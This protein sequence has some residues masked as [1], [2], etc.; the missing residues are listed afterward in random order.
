MLARNKMADVAAAPLRSHLPA[1]ADQSDPRGLLKFTT[2]IHVRY[3][4]LVPIEL[5]ISPFDMSFQIFNSGFQKI[6][7]TTPKLEICLNHTAYPWAHEAG[8]YIPKEDQMFV[9]SNRIH[10]ADGTQKIQISKISLRNDGTCLR[11]EI[12][13]DI[14]MANGGVNYKDGVLFCSQGT[15]DQPSSLIFMEKTTPYKC[16]VILDSFYGRQFN[17]INDVVVHGDGSIWFTDPIYG[18]E[19]NFRPL[20]QLPNQVYRYDPELQ[21]VRT[22]ADGF[23]RPNGICFSPD[24][25]VVYITDT[26]SIHG[27]GTV[28]LNRPSTM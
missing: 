14:P 11:E 19:Q 28:N 25:R 21:S 1:I 10:G 23:G 27:D 13:P 4:P 6:T 3:L 5:P 24:E 22:V 12:A 20:P 17:S 26:D 7:G 8:V 2:T 15:Q 9:T 16:T 18:Y